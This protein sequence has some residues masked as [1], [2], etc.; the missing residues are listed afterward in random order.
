MNKK[1]LKRLD[2]FEK[3]LEAL[4]QN[5]L[6]RYKCQLSSKNKEIKMLRE[7]NNELQSKL[8]TLQKTNND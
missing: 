2:E 1:L 7:Q 5:T 4:E 6:V 3:R 8:E